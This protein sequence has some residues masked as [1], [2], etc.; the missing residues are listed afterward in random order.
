MNYIKHFIGEMDDHKIQRCILCGEVLVD[1]SSA[2]SRDG[3]INPWESGSIY[4]STGNPQNI[5]SEYGLQYCDTSKMNIIDCKHQA[6]KT[7]NT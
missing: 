3:K 6:N 5:I 4:F 1:Y 7:E 2:Y